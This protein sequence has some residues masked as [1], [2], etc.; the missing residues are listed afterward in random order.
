MKNKKV[1]ILLIAAIL[2]IL[3]GIIALNSISNAPSPNQDE[4]KDAPRIKVFE[5]NKEVLSMTFNAGESFTLVKKDD[6]WKVS[7]REYVDLDQNSVISAMGTLTGLYASRALEPEGEF[8]DY[9]IDFE[10]PTALVEFADSTSKS[11]YLGDILPDG[12]GYYCSVEGFDFVYVISKLS[13]Q[14]IGAALLDF[15]NLTVIDIDSQSITAFSITGEN[16]LISM[17]YKLNDVH[18][19]VYGVISN[20]KMTHPYVYDADNEA[21][22]A[23]ILT[24][25][26]A[27]LAYDVAEDLVSY[28]LPYS[29]EVKADGKTLSFKAGFMDDFALVYSEQNGVHYK[30]SPEKLSFLNVTFFDVA[31]KFL[32]II[33]LNTLDSATVYANGKTSVI[34][35]PGANESQKYFIDGKEYTLD[36]FRPYYQALISG[37]VDG[38]VPSGYSKKGEMLASIKFVLKDSTTE[39]FEFYDYDELNCAVYE[40]GKC[41]FYM[42]RT[43]LDYMLTVLN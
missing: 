4:S 40:N 6:L 33:D 15:R 37:E 18:A 43:L 34:T 8:S 13:A 22:T 2:L 21:V 36:E 1:I 16:G 12:S 30:V 41:L 7:G 42:R 29:F 17:N 3:I 27:I 39:Y 31:E 25:I 26:S 14:N 9:G 5:T 28:R 32:S 20:W 10:N 24:P 19:D 35:T 38:E 11:F 23:L